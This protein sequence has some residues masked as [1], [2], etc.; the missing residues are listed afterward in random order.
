M[1]KVCLDGF[2]MGKHEVTQGQWKK[3]M[4]SNTSIHYR[5][6]DSYPVDTVSWNDTKEFIQKLEKSSGK[7]DKF[8]LPT[9]A[10]WEYACRAGTKTIYYWGEKDEDACLYENVMDEDGK[11]FFGVDKSFPCKDGYAEPAPVGHF[12]PNK[13]GL[14]D[15][16]GNVTEWC[17]D[18]F[19][20]LAYM[21]HGPKNPINDGWS[22]M[23][24]VRGNDWRSD[25]IYTRCAKR[26]SSEQKVPSP[27][28]GFRLVREPL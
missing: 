8:R 7:K 19:N 5:K 14:H 27:T 4:G 25:D 21:K 24:V 2:W 11:R 6:G 10:E 22:T 26:G 3:I 1:H 28:R 13:F 12:K 9:E 15:M 20:P 17:E 18:T 16:L 23:R